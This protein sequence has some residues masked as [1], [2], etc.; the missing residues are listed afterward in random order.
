MTEREASQPEEGKPAEKGES[1]YS[2]FSLGTRV[3]DDFGVQ[4]GYTYGRDAN[5]IKLF[6]TASIS[7]FYRWTDKWEFE[8]RQSFSLLEDQQLG[9]EMV[10]RRYG[11]DLIF[12]LESKLR[13]GEGSAIGFSVRPRLGFKPNRI[14]YT[15]W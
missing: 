13:E 3:H 15:N 8:A 1:I 6:D 5:L 4:V 9:F 11:H 7:G 14:G 2:H 10:L 12:E